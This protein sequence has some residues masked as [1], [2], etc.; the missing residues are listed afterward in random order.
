[1][2]CLIGSFLLGSAA[3]T[4]KGPLVERLIELPEPGPAPVLEH[5]EPGRVTQPITIR[6]GA[7]F[8]GIAA[9]YGLP[10]EA[11]LTVSRPHYD[12]TR[13]RP[14][15][16]L[17]VSWTQGEVEPIELSYTI[18]E[19][20]ILILS[21]QPA[22]WQAELH[23][24]E[25]AV[26]L[27]ARSFEI[28]RSLWQDGLQAGLHP[29][30]LARLAQIFEYELD[31]NTE[32]RAG[33]QFSLVADV[34]SAEGRASRLGAI[35]A[36]RLVN[37]EKQWTAFRFELSDGSE[38]W[39]QSDGTSLRK[40]F[41]RSPLEFSRVTSGFNPKRFHPIL[42]K[43]RPHNGT[44]FGAPTGTP[45]RS[46]ADGKVVQAGW[47][48]GHGRFVKVQHDGSYATSYSHLSRIDVKSGSRVKQGQVIGAVGAT[49]LATGPHLH[50][51]MWHKGRFVDPMK[52]K[53]PNQ[54]PLPSSAKA[55]FQ[56]IV[57]RWGPVLERAAHGT[58]EP[59][60]LHGE[61]VLVE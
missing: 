21:R 34:L 14:D 55:A 10:S 26:E 24:V 35:H 59:D 4:V 52:I 46:V 45:V 29:A 17:L 41:L 27:G 5:L 16:E 20:R 37:G 1:M 12:L 6:R 32:L 50:F 23:E 57:E 2:V 3:A 48:G 47:A 7:T 49:G 43:P 31:F 15:R 54:A 13:I 40:P 28:Q 44:D 30:G 19:D 60:S 18:D 25:Y 22:G 8:G 11:L 42:K 33:A 51:Q 58:L 39:Y 9:R 53:L 56:Q 38:S 61:G 36:V